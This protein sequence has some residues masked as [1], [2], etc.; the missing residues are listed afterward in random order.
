LSTASITSGETDI[1]RLYA[2]GFILP[3][4]PGVIELPL[5]DAVRT[6]R[7]RRLDRLL[8]PEYLGYRLPVGALQAYDPPFAAQA[9]YLAYLSRRPFLAAQTGGDLWLEASRNDS[10]GILQRRSYASAKAILATNP[11]TYAHARRFGFRHIIYAPLLVD[12]VRYSP[13]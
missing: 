9:P 12:T 10:P 13:G 5:V 8:W 6:R 2:G 3:T 11:W 4:V 7:M 1:D